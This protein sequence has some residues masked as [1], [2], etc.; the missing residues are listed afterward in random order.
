MKG[1]SLLFIVQQTRPDSSIR[2]L[3][4]WANRAGKLL[5][6]EVGVLVRFG[7]VAR[8]VGTLVLEERVVHMV[9]LL[10]KLYLKALLSEER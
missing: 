6:L 3:L 7:V 1:T 10:A 5:A 2:D 8:F 9:A 4:N